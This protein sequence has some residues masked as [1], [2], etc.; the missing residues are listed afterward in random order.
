MSSPLIDKFSS[1]RNL[2]RDFRFKRESAILSNLDMN[3]A[4]V[5]MDFHRTNVD[6]TTFNLY[7]R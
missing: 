2:S 7:L 1:S 5:E 6:N 4:L 3:A